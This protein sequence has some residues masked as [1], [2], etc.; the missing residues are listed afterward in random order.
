MSATDEPPALGSTGK[1]TGNK[2]HVKHYNHNKNIKSFLG[3]HLFWEN[4]PNLTQVKHLTFRR[5]IV[6][7]NS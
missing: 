4:G 5:D 1:Y 2:K 3:S 7:M 6:W